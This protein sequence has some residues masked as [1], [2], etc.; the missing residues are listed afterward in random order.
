MRRTTISHFSFL[1]QERLSSTIKRKH[2]LR[3][4]PKPSG[5]ID[6]F[7]TFGN[8][9]YLFSLTKVPFSCNLPFL[10]LS[11]VVGQFHPISG[12]QGI[13]SKKNPEDASA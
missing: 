13:N 9:I 10:P 7:F 12:T 8:K 11:G 5:I 4:T 6:F 3:A 2:A 1:I